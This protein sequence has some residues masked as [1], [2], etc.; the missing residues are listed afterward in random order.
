MNSSF[1][2]SVF[3][4]YSGIFCENIEQ[5]SYWYVFET[6]HTELNQQ[7]ERVPD[8]ARILPGC[9]LSDETF[10]ELIKLRGGNNSPIL[11]K[12][13]SMWV[14]FIIKTATIHD[15][16]RSRGSLRETKPHFL[17]IQSMLL[18]VTPAGCWKV[19]QVWSCSWQERSIHK[20]VLFCPCNNQKSGK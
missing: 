15:D 16:C 10:L 1:H 12:I 8:L 7:P 14:N 2:A 19:T 20:A 17:N 6:K 11:E 13:S 18:Q 9:W 3:N 5:T 4:H